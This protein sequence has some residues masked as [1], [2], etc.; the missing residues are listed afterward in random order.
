[1]KKLISLFQNANV[2]LF[3]IAL[4]GR[5]F[6]EANFSFARILGYKSMESFFSEFTWERH[7]SIVGQSEPFSL[8]HE[9]ADTGY[10][11]MRICR[12]D[13]TMGWVN[14][15]FGI[16]LKT[17]YVDGMIVD[18]SDQKDLEQE[19]VRISDMEREKFGRDLHDTLGQTLTGTAFLCRALMQGLP[20]KTALIEE[21]V[22]Q[23]ENLV[24]QA[25]D[26]ARHLAHG[27]TYIEVKPAAIVSHLKK[28]AAQA[29]AVFGGDCKVRVLAKV[30]LRDAESATNLYRIA[31]E[32]VH[33]AIK[34]SGSPKVEI[35]LEK[36]AEMGTMTVKDFGKGLP[37]SSSRPKGIGLQLMKLRARLIGGSIR[38]FNRQDR[39]F[40]VICTFPL[41]KEKAE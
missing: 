22:G 18:I 5:K 2:G 8:S 4:K 24:K 21:R 36:N 41:A 38:F 7:F 39:G 25:L 3:V 6:I 27:L 29:N 32:A 19:I 31:Q 10:R 9:S 33:N 40:R 30:I 34:H 12:A 35:R 26:Q 20:K 16:Y 15:S 17:G 14:F 23:I 11:E 1:M 28:L 37:R 13:G